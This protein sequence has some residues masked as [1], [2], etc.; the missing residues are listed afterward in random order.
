MPNKAKWLI[1]GDYSELDTEWVTVTMCVPNTRGWRGIVTGA[2][3]NLTRGRYYD[4]TTGI[5]T[6]AQ[7]IGERI[8]DSLAMDCNNNWER[9]AV[10]LESLDEK[11]PSPVTLQEFMD[12]LA[13]AETIEAIS[14]WLGLGTALANILPHLHMKLT[15]VE[16]VKMFFEI[17]WR[18]QV[19]GSA[20]GIEKWLRTLAMVETGETG[21]EV[22]EAVD[23]WLDNL[24]DWAGLVLQGGSMFSQAASAFALLQGW[25]SS[26]GGNENEEIRNVNRVYNDIFVTEGAMMNEQNQ[27]V[28][29]SCGCGGQSG[30][31]GTGG[32]TGFVADQS[33]NQTTVDQPAINPSDPY[34]VDNWPSD[35]DSYSDWQDYKCKASNAMVLNLAE[36]FFQVFDAPNREH[37]QQTHSLVVDSLRIYFTAV[38]FMFGMDWLY[39]SQFYTAFISWEAEQI[40]DYIYQAVDYS[41]FSIFYDIRLEML[42]NREDYVCAIFSAGN[43]GMVEQ[44]LTDRITAFI[45]GTSYSTEVQAWATSV[46]QDMLSSYWLNIP[47]VHYDN[48]AG[49]DD[50]GAIDCQTCGGYTYPAGTAVCDDPTC[51][52]PEDGLGQNDGIWT[53][54]ID[55]PGTWTATFA[56]TYEIIEGMTLE[57]NVDLVAGGYANWRFR[58]IIDDVSYS[59]RSLNTI[60]IDGW[61]GG[62]LDTW[63]GDTLQGMEIFVDDPGPGQ[64]PDF[65]VDGVRIGG[66]P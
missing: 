13:D 23:S 55:T 34:S 2:I 14:E 49:F 24:T 12:S 15:P 61:Y 31:G 19:A 22:A 6:V 29:V 57:A 40:A 8:F 10:S 43:S 1:P 46:F 18:G 4:E 21:A 7:V 64:D 42:E 62:S 63:I 33:P 54:A 11:F 35:F 30:C 27:T 36:A 58:A 17:R 38:D 60:N 44:E 65:A 66:L 9:M 53:E 39:T 3:Y 26:D 28:N 47:F 25:F 16:W 37:P 51:T 50:A 5:I 59:I 41:P 32:S 52:N 45:A 20:D 48:I 56:S